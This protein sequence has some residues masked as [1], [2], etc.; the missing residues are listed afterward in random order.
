MAL[1]GVVC[2]PGSVDGVTYAQIN[3]QQVNCG[4][5]SNGNTLYVQVSTLSGD[6]PVAGGEAVG[7]EIGGAVLAVL[8]VA[9]GLRVLR[10]HFNSG[11]EA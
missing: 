3:G 7:I 4:T 6:Q 10:D 1:S 11:G 9:W 5:D 8:G 2:G